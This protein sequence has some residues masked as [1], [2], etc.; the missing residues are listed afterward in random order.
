MDNRYSFLDLFSKKVDYDKESKVTITSVVIPQIQRPYAQGR[1]DGVCTY[2]RNTFLD[3]IFETLLNDGDEILDLN[4]IYGI[5]EPNNDEY[6]LELLDGQQR[7]TTL[8]LLYWYVANAELTDSSDD[9]SYV[10][11]SLSKFLYETRATSTVFGQELSKFNVDF[12]GDIPSKAIRK[13]KW[14]F[15]SFDRDSTICAML[16][17]LDAIHER[18]IKIQDPHLYPKLDRLRFYVKSLGVFNLSEELY[19]KMNARGLQL[20]PFENFK[21]DLTNFVSNKQYGAYRESVPLYKKNSSDTVPFHF[22]F[23]VKLDAKWVDI[24]WK[25][26]ADDFDDA[27][28]SFFSRFFACK[29]IISSKNRVNDRDMRTDDNL[30]SFY[31]N[32]EDQLGTNEYFGFKQFYILLEEHP[33]YILT[34]DKVFD[35]FYSFDFASEDKCIFRNMLPIW[36]K[37][38]DRE[39]D[40]FY[41]NSKAKM[42]H[43]KLIAFSAVIEFVEAMP[44]FEPVI[45]GQW[46]R[47]VWNVIE[48][49]NIDSLTPVS[50]LVRKFSAII[51]YVAEKMN[52]GQTFY[53]ALSGWHD[54]NSSERENRAVLE[55]IEKARRISEDPAWEDVWRGVEKHDYFK[56][57]ATFFYKPSMSMMDYLE[58]SVVVTGMFDRNG[59]SPIYTKQHILIRAIMSHYNTW[60]DINEQYITERSESNQHL[61]NILASN[62][63]VRDMF[64]EV[65]YNKT[66]PDVTTALNEFIN[67][68]EEPQAWQNADENDV[69]AFNMAIKRLRND[70][71][72]YD[73]IS[74]EEQDKK[75]CFRVYWYEGHI[76]FA[77]PKKQY[78]KI[79][80]DTE[81]AKMAFEL[82][83]DYGFEFFDLNQ[84]NMYELYRDCFGN[85]LWVK[86]ARTNCVVWVGFLQHHRLIIQIES[87][88]KKYAKEL[89]SQFE[90]SDY[91]DGDEVCIELPEMRHDSKNRTYKNLCE[92]IE[93]VLEMIPEKSGF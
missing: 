70:V 43:T 9:N 56:G 87:K 80:L 57:L 52:E 71:K 50:S 66:I 19:I 76:M 4:F 63:K 86:Q 92:A 3:G 82:C 35:V 21:A 49:T 55:E 42:S 26:G 53:S 38:D 18:Y 40:D 11:N 74:L 25:N 85:D 68:A 46:T 34:L 61:K 12:S 17:M 79:A 23:S 6:K 58:N 93:K 91:V 54:D 81:R 60:S 44:S 88:T 47:V 15:K 28:M 48:N 16:T 39:G 10:R 41:C 78:A 24:F 73:W 83:R 69:R 29:Y 32:A 36:D 84:R 64:C 45:F 14:Y 31:T 30:K 67:K 75:S 72:M 8:F 59:I 65:A 77:I 2:V 37:K 89:L 13:A 20:S 90:G 22:N 51:H 5:I 7:L 27:Y 33:E 62:D 1:L